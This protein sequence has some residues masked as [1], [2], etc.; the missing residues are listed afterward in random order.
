MTKPTIS[1]EIFQTLRNRI[2]QWEYPPGYRLT[3]EALCQEF[4][5]S[6]IPVRE[7]LHLLEESSLV[8]KVPHQGCTVRQLNER[9]INELY[10]V[11]LALEGFV[12]EYLAGNGMDEAIW[13]QLYDHWQTLYHTN[14]EADF[15][16]NLLAKEDES[17]HE[18]LAQATMNETLVTSLKGINER[19]AFV[20]FTDITTL[21]RLL[22]T[23][24]QHLPI[25]E[26]I[27]DGNALGAKEAMWLNIEYGRRNVE[28][29]LKDV[30]SKAYL[31]H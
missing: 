18:T 22:E 30:L 11:R 27:R 25:L 4:N 10:D 20:R 21:E 15:D 9:E 16:A 29:A 17:F 1:S 19:L 13:Q 23:C 14:P 8:E 28:A 7:A 2:I 12:V 26:H 31:L 24:Q 6:R 3:E 5:V